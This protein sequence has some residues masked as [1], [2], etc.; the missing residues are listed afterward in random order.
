MNIGKGDVGW[1]S[2]ILIGYREFF[3]K[4]GAIV[5]DGWGNGGGSREKSVDF[6]EM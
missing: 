4:K 6:S 2:S 3:L 1:F 5:G